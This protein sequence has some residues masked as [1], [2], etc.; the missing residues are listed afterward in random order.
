MYYKKITFDTFNG[1]HFKLY[2]LIIQYTLGV[3]DICRCNHFYEA[4]ILLTLSTLREA[5]NDSSEFNFLFSNFFFWSPKIIF[6][7][8]YCPYILKAILLCIKSVDKLLSCQYRAA[9]WGRLRP[10]LH[11]FFGLNV[12][13]FI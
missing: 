7:R 9:F 13:C 6:H 4:C 1:L 5:E 11:V 2:M 3:W 12:Y 8:I 10:F